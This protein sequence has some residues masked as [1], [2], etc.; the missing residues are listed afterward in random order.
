MEYYEKTIKDLKEKL[1]E[2]I[3]VKEGEVIINKELKILI[4]KLELQNELLCKIN[5][6]LYKE[7]AELRLKIKNNLS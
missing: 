4:E 7:I 5:D 3:S 1:G 2:E 6:R